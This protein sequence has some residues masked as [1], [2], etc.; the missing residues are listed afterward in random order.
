VWGAPEPKIYDFL[1]DPHGLGWHLD[2]ARFDAWLRREAVLRGAALIQPATV[3]FITR[4]DMFHVRARSTSGSL[5]LSASLII[6]AAGRS[7][8]VARR[9]G[10]QRIVHD[11]LVSVYVHGKDTYRE[12]QAM[13]LIEAVEDGFW[14][15]APTPEGGRVLAFHTDADLPRLRALRAPVALLE[16]AY[17]TREIARTLTLSGF[18]V[19]GQRRSIAAHSASLTPCTGEGWLATCDAAIAFD[20]LSSQGLLNALFTGLAAAEAAS[21]HLEGE[22]SALQEYEHTIAGIRHAYR[23]NHAHFYRAE[24]RWPQAPFWLRRRRE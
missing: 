14:Y 19:E 10:A 8:P 6:D 7:S 1:W 16:H 22:S 5:D 13:T 11:K 24:G 23:R 3:E 9:L 17:R 21:R 18:Q 4:T 20:P 12:T 15:T 2:R